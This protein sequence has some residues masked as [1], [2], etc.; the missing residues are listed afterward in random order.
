M[1]KPMPSR[2]FKNLVAGSVGIRKSRS[3]SPA[4]IRAVKQFNPA[5]V[6]GTEYERVFASYLE[7]LAALG[8]EPG[9][10]S[11]LLELSA[12]DSSLPE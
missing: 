10:R 7:A 9:V 12:S 1:S 6:T 4:L 2:R 3:A 5:K 11:T 8:D